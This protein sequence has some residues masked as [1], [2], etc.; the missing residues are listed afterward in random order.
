MLLFWGKSMATVHDVYLFL[1]DTFFQ[2]MERMVSKRLRKGLEKKDIDF[3]QEV[4][5]RGERLMRLVPE[6]LGISE[7]ES[8]HIPA[9]ATIGPRA[10]EELAALKQLFRL[11]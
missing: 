11:S 7:E 9:T 10:E 4:F 6:E 5:S 8:R 1:Q 2:E 3:L